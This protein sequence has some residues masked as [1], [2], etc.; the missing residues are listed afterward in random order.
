MAKP[1]EP[2]APPKTKWEASAERRNARAVA[3]APL[4]AHAGLVP[5]VTAEEQQRHVEGMAD[6]F[7]ARTAALHARH[8]AKAA[9][10]RAEVAGHVTA[11]AI[12]ALEQRLTA[13]PKSPEYLA[14]FWR[15]ELLRLFPERRK[16]SAALRFA[17]YPHLD[18]QAMDGV[19]AAQLA[20]ALRA[21]I[22][23]DRPPHALELEALEALDD[24]AGPQRIVTAP[25]RIAGA[26]ADIEADREAEA[27]EERLDR[28]VFV[29]AE[30]S[31]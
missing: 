5:V 18:A 27:A 19:P 7:A 31:A 16:L 24:A 28:P 29:R 3:K 11:E 10:W 1:K 15:G 22:P 21:A 30:G 13:I 6:D 17:G 20:T 25:A 14:D 9:Q 12:A 4:F 8:R 26:S 23:A 2:K